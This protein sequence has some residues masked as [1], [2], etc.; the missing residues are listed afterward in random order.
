MV[1]RLIRISGGRHGDPADTTSTAGVGK[2]KTVSFRNNRYPISIVYL[3]KV[4]DIAWRKKAVFN[5]IASS[6]G[7]LSGSHSLTHLI[8]LVDNRVPM[9][10]Y[11][12]LKDV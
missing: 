2:P 9:N 12:A 11:S 10:T 7:P 4:L 8:M 5:L 1:S 3:E 6:V